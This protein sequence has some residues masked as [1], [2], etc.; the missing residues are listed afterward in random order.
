MALDNLNLSFGTDTPIKA[1]EQDLIGRAPFTERLADF[2]KDVSQNLIEA[3]VDANHTRKDFVAD[4]AL[5]QSP[6]SC[7]SPERAER[8]H[9]NEHFDVLVIAFQRESLNCAIR[10]EVS[11]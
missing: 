2:L 4:Q 8:G 3:I 1:R 11:G 7:A 5:L 6:G 9:R 10:L